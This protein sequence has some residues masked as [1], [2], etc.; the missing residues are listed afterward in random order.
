MP[1]N[2]GQQY[3]LFFALEM[4]WMAHTNLVRK[5]K[6]DMLPKGNAMIF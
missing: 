4:K 2:E 1:H 3:K 5:G 6:I